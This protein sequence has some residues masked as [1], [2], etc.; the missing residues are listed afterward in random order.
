VK[1]PSFDVAQVIKLSLSFR[2]GLKMLSHRGC[3]NEFADPRT[4]LNHGQGVLRE[5][6]N[7]CLAVLASRCG[8]TPSLRFLVDFIPLDLID[9]L[10]PLSGERQKFHN[11]QRSVMVR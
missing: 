5:M 6:D 1:P 7:M 11:A 8:D 9:L 2:E 10:A 4:T 3:E